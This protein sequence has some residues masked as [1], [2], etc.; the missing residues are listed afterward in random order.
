MIKTRGILKSADKIG[1]RQKQKVI[2]KCL[3]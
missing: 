1:G 3:P 2:T